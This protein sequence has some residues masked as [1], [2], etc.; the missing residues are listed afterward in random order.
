MLKNRHGTE[1]QDT[2]QVCLNG[3]VINADYHKYSELNRHN[4]DRCGE[5]TITQCLNPE[6]NKPIPGNLRKA[7]GMIIESQ[8][9]APDFC[10]YC[11]KAFPWHKNEA[12]KYLEI[13]IEK[14]IETL[15]K[16]ISK[17]HSI[18][19]KLRNRYNSRETLAVKD[20]YDVQDLLDA[21]LV[22][23]FE[24]I[25]REEPTPSY[26]TKSAKI[27]F[28]LKYEKIGIEVKMTRKGLADKEIGEQLIIAYLLLRWC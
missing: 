2:M 23:Y 20:E 9:T 10:P 1:Q 14:P 15:Q 13:G 22:L 6:C 8:Q 28:L 11:S 19:K 26:A 12:A 5:K 3:H 7:T 18:V 17:F 27:D 24:D 25:R 16:V 4:C 21:L